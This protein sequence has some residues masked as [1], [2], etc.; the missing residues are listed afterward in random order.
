MKMP[1]SSFVLAIVARHLTPLGAVAVMAIAAAVALSPS[2]SARGEGASARRGLGVAS[3]LRGR[4]IPQGSKFAGFLGALEYRAAKGGLELGRIGTIPIKLFE[5]DSVIVFGPTQS[6]KTSRLVIPAITAFGGAVIATSVKDDIVRATVA[7][8]PTSRPWIFDPYG[9]SKHANCYWNPI[10]PEMAPDLARRLAGTICAP[11]NVEHATEESAFWYALAARM[12]EP[13]LVAASLSG[14]D[15]RMVMDWVETR[16]FTQPAGALERGERQRLRMALLAS[17][18]REERQL[19]SVITTLE[20]CLEPFLHGTSAVLGW[21]NA[22]DFK[23]QDGET[24]YLV[25]PPNR[26]GEVGPVFGTLLRIH[27]DDVFARPPKSGLLLV[28]DEAANIAP[29]ANLDEVVSVISAYKVQMMTIFQDFSQVRARYGD[30]AATVVNNHRAKLFLGAISDP[31][32]IYLAETLC[33][34]AMP[35]A[36]RRSHSSAPIS[37]ALLPRGGLRSLRPGDG[38]LI[39]GHRNP[40]LL[41]LR[42]APH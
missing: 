31:E 28:L 6:Y 21:R 42:S 1:A 14:G 30:R 20:K 32:T 35:T 16:D 8:R 38:L 29:I 37:E 39:Y 13:L 27:L 18:D 4:R 9:I 5:R 26:Q 34:S 23:V 3:W 15:I 36:S 40:A 7:S 19:S 25:A 12:A 22:A 11:R 10:G 41:R 2:E 24:L 33:G 17:L